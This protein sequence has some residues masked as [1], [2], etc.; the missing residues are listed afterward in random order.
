MPKSQRVKLILCPAGT[1]MT[2]GASMEPHPLSSATRLE[3]KP[4]DKEVSI[5]GDDL[6]SS[7]GPCRTGMTQKGE[8]ATKVQKNLI[9]LSMSSITLFSVSYAMSGPL[10]QL[11]RRYHEIEHHI[12]STLHHRAS[13]GCQRDH[14]RCIASKVLGT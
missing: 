8:N 4:R 2:Q 5:M 11:H 9:K 10:C 14:Q 6:H 3:M 7:L 12:C 1:V 13:K